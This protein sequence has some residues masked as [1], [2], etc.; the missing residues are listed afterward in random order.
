MYANLVGFLTG[1]LPRDG[2]NISFPEL[3]ST[4]RATYN[5]APSFCFFVPNFAARMLNKSYKKDKIDLADLDF[6][7]GIEHDASL[8]RE[9]FFSDVVTKRNRQHKLNRQRYSFHQRSREA[10]PS[11]REGTSQLCIREGQGRKRAP[12]PS[13]PFSLF[14]QASCRVSCQQPRVLFRPVPQDCW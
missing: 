5:F 8:T 14:L 1:I 9:F 11:F 3:Y 13:R 12:Y 10:P 6:H 7:N 2:K 4:V